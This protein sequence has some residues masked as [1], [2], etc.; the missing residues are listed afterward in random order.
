MIITDPPFVISNKKNVNNK[1]NGYTSFK[2]DWDVVVAEAHM[3]ERCLYT[4][5]TC[6]YEVNNK[7]K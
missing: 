2:G 7:Y 1:W 6:D 5:F 4:I 3:L